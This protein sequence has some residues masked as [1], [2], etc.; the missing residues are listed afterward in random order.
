MQT[1]VF[2]MLG[3]LARDRV[4]NLGMGMLFSVLGVGIGFWLVPGEP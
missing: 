2:L 3:W 4:G 1:G